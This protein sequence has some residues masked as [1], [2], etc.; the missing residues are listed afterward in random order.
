ML[1]KSVNSFS[2]AL[3]ISKNSIIDVF[4][5]VKEEIINSKDVINSLIVDL[6]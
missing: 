3:I 4:I 6:F 1:S 2:F 5:R